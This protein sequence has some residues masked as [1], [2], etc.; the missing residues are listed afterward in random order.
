MVCLGE[1]FFGPRDPVTISRLV[2]D[3]KS[4]SARRLN[5]QRQS[6]GP[7]WQHQFW[8]RFVRHAQEFG[9]RLDY[10]HFNPVTRGLVDNP[11]DWPW[12]SI[13]SFGGPGLVRLAV[14][15]LNLPCN[16]RARLQRNFRILKLR[17][18]KTFEKP[19]D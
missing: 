8:D 3:V 6:H 5:R 10:M 16:E 17:F 11:E 4:V 9:Q 1:V 14:D 12:S 7:L 13:H 15:L 2:Q 18:F 19:Q